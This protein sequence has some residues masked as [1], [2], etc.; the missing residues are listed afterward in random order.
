[1]FKVAT[2][3]LAQLAQEPF[4]LQGRV[5]TQL[6]FLRRKFGSCALGEWICGTKGVIEHPKGRFN[7][8]VMESSPARPRVASS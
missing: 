5:I 6:D 8:E 3:I 2:A 4:Q 7:L 1:M